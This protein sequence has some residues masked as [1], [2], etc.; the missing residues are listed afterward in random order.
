M[1]TSERPPGDISRNDQI[2]IARTDFPG[3]DHLQ[4]VSVLVCARRDAGGALCS[5][6]YGANG[7]DF[8]QRKCPKC[9]DGAPGLSL[10]GWFLS[11]HS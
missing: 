6:R 5:H 7:S 11:F 9:H 1:T 2:L 10:K 8:F 4:Y 3:N